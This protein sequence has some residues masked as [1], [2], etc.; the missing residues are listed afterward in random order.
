MKLEPEDLQQK[1]PGARVT[2]IKRLKWILIIIALATFILSNL[3]LYI[4][5][6]QYDTPFIPQVIMIV[7]TLA[8]LIMLW[9]AIRLIGQISFLEQTVGD[10]QRTDVKLRRQLDELKLLHIIA[11][12]GTE[13]TT[14]NEL[15]DR[16][17]QLINDA[18]HPDNFGL[19]LI[20]SVNE[21]LK[22]HNA[23]HVSNGVSSPRTMP[24]NSGIVGKVALDGQARRI[25]DVT[26]DPDYYQI[27]P[28][29]RSELCV[30]LKIGGEVI[31]VINTESHHDHA[32]T[33]EDERLF[34]TFAGQLA[35][36]LDR[37]RHLEAAHHH[38]Q[39]LTTLYDVGNRVISILTLDELLPEIVR[40]IAQ[41]LNL[42]N[43]E[44]GLVE[45]DEL[46][47]HAG[48]GG[49][50]G[51]EF[52]PGSRTQIGQGVAG[53]VAQTG[54]TLLASDVGECQAFVPSQSL[55]EICAE[56]AVPLQIKGNVIG[57]LDVKSDRL[58]GL[59]ASD[60]AVLETLASQLAVAIQNAQYV[61]ALRKQT[62]TLSGLYE[63]ALVTSSL[64]PEPRALLRKLYEQV[65]LLMAPDLFIAA[66]YDEDTQTITIPLAMQGEHTLPGVNEINITLEK[67]GLTGWVLQ[68]RQTLFIKDLET[69]D[70]PAQPRYVERARSWLGVPLI[71]RNRLVGTLSVQ[72]YQPGAFTQNDQRF[73]ESLARQVAI[74]LENMRLFE[75][76]QKRNAELESLRQ[77][78]LATTSSLNS[79]QVLQAIMDHA[80]KIANADDT[81][82]FLY[83]GKRLS[84]GAARWSG[85]NQ[86]GPYTTPR[87]HG[88]T[89]SVAR[90]G[91]RLVVADARD[92]TI[93]HDSPWDGAI[94]GLPLRIGQQVIGVM[95]VSFKK[96]HNFNV[97][98]LRAL[99]LLADQAA[100]ALRNAELFEA[101]NR[102]LKELTILHAI[103]TVGAETTNENTLIEHTTQ[104]IGKTLYPDHFGIMLLDEATQTLNFH[105]SYHGISEAIRT[106][107]IP[108]G[109]GITGTVAQ[110]GQSWLVND[111]AQVPN[112]IATT[113]N[114]HSEL[115]IPLQVDEH[116]I[117]VINAESTQEYAFT[118]NDQRL[119]TTLAGQLA[120]AI[121]KV[122]LFTETA[123]ALVREQ[124]LNEIARTIS[125]ELDIDTIL[126]NVVRLA[127]ELTGAEAGVMALLNTEGNLLIDHY[128]F[129][130]P[131][132][133]EAMRSPKKQ[134]I[135]WQLIEY[136]KPV[137]FAEYNHHSD[138]LPELIQAGIQSSIGVPIL[139]GGEPIGAL[140]LFRIQQ[141]TRFSE[142]DLDLLEAVG[143]QAGIAIQ[144]ARYIAEIEARASELERALKRS[145]ELEQLKN[146]FIQN[147]SH[148]LRTPLAITRGYAELLDNG[149][150]GELLPQQRQPV[151]IIYR[152]IKMLV[153]MVE[154]LT[155]ILEAESQRLRKEP[156]DM[157]A[158][159]QNAL[160]DFKINAAK[161]KVILK[162]K[163]EITKAIV[164][165]DPI[166]LRRVLDNL[167]GNAL[168]FTP[169]GGSITIG[170]RT[171]ADGLIVEVTDTG[172]GIPKDNLSRIFE[173]FYQVDGS[174]KRRYGGTGLGL[175]LVKEIVEAH[176]GQVTVEST[177][178]VG[179]T[180]RFILP[181]ASETE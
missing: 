177:V 45:G 99:E 78:S 8:L 144:N 179:S 52:D 11:V 130:I 7:T 139:A 35:T 47:F 155:A 16:S 43:V 34:I 6:P 108:L 51:G 103:A 3:V 145:Q 181:L 77:A 29:T 118:A 72:S 83:D 18:L 48:Y 101:A 125:A 172:I 138:A 160:A 122:R 93:F 142:R 120:T 173:R 132:E 90:S 163:L 57:V 17:M 92:H 76:I 41:T 81:H 159:T 53:T 105:A 74:T 174:A 56:L 26:R 147:V 65:E 129:N 70:L 98:E 164:Q 79:E 37:L 87:E 137:L 153:T 20:D 9:S 110:D 24:L 169:A 67:G 167:L 39:Q 161:A 36:A 12:A 158:L 168:K 136:Q 2:N 42:Y 113:P 166:H 115:C 73:F 162:A 135:C 21:Q 59:T 60:A 27:D 143:L 111:I 19:L 170:M 150:L 89:Y 114:I 104:L 124:R 123:E 40:L 75:A 178:D 88:V 1:L 119:L 38:T 121:E 63:T 25:Q 33:E 84:F 68:N 100:I 126:H 15:L 23:Y 49:Y 176:G 117:G 141:T 134:G 127:A 180:F 140:A 156:T 22:L 148:E 14:E 82:I 66:L 80:L 157:V 32:F 91:E 116:V 61:E 175:A 69:E 146:Q 62:N 128:Y 171:Q 31:G 4:L 58:Y 46:V 154:E 96:P 5:L 28:Q 50:T 106:M 97:N 10:L 112:Y 109:K 55:P 44:I 151:E 131:D 107:R 102:Q 64:I 152:R 95:N 71:V 165:G 85:E 133:I 94:A 86:S 30:P 54:R 13:V 149:T